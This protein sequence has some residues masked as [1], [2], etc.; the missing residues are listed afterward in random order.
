[1]QEASEG[2]SLKNKLIENLIKFE[3]ITSLLIK[4]NK[5]K[6]NQVTLLSILID[7]IRMDQRHNGIAVHG[8][9]SAVPLI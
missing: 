7:V 9:N 1:M 5:I 3:D 4:E 2:S 8:E 6:I